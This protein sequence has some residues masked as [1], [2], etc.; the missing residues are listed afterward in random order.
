MI[1]N[2]N[3]N[4]N[5]SY[6]YSIED[7]KTYEKVFSFI[8]DE[9][10]RN[11]L[12]FVMQNIVFE[13]QIYEDDRIPGPLKYS[14]GK[15]IIINTVSIIEALCHYWIIYKINEQGVPIE[16]FFKKKSNYKLL[17]SLVI[18]IDNREVVAA[19]RY[20]NFP[21][22]NKKLK[23]ADSLYALKHKSLIDDSFYDDLIKI[24]QW[25]NLI[26]LKSLQDPER[27][28]FGNEDIKFSFRVTE[29][30]EDLIKSDLAS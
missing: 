24:K 25:R 1:Q 13:L 21:D 4:Q 3:I 10:L 11:N 20:K 28:Y 22:I 12:A 23:L 6:P 29:K 2:K 7:I 27:R 26:H 30:L 5:D 18:S 8:K 16:D 19:F 14:I 17:K 15:E 9:L